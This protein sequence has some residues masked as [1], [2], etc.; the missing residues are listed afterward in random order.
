M[1]P[2][3]NKRNLPANNQNL[4]RDPLKSLLKQFIDSFFS[5]IQPKI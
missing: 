1:V 3:N 2:S 5:I 4:E